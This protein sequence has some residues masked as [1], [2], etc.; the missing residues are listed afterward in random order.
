VIIVGAGP[1]GLVTAYGLARAGI[2]VTV[3]EA[4]AQVVDSP[5]AM[6]YHWALLEDLDQLGLLEAIDRRGFRK[7]DY[8]YRVHATGETLTYT[9]KAL[10]DETPYPYNIHLGQDELC[11]IVLERLAGLPNASVHW[12]SP[13]TAVSQD[14]TEARATTAGDDVDRHHVGSWVIGC[15]GARSTVRRLLG[16][17]FA[18]TTWPQRFVATNVFFDFDAHGYTRSVFLMDDVYGAVIAKIN[19]E[20]LWRVTYSEDLSLPEGQIG[21]RVGQYFAEILPDGG[22]YELE[23]FSGY[24]LHQRTAERWRVGRVLLAGDAAHATNP[25]GGFGLAS[26]LFGAFSLIRT[27]ASVILDG[28]PDELIDRWA[29]ER[30]RIFLEVASPAATRMKR[31]VYESDRDAGHETL[32]GLRATIADPAAFRERLR[33]PSRLKSAQGP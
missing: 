26:G 22:P 29:E 20:N 27:F 33:F 32:E 31:T 8:G 15:D 21:E 11:A 19:S 24:R 6:V 12:E 25:T 4:E 9:L 16:V 1:V 28:A 3:L 7:D 14:A 30:R 23:R 18:G 2:P 17:A 13:V 10:S 5:R